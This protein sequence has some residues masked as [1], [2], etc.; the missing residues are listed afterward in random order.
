MYG[1]IEGVQEEFGEESGDALLYHID[2][3]IS[4]KM[5]EIYGKR[6]KIKDIEEVTI[7]LRAWLMAGPG[8]R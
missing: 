2:F 6:M 4:K 7:L 3:G 1:F 8:K 5:Y